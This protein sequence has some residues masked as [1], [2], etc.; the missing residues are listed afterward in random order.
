MKTTFQ[1]FLGLISSLVFSIYAQPADCTSDFSIFVEYAKT[2]NY[3]AAYTP[4]K[5][6]VKNCPSYHQATYLYGEKILKFKIESATTKADKEVFVR[7]LMKMYDDYDTHFPDNNKGNGVSKAMAL[8]DN[9]IGTPEEQYALLDKAFTSD[10]KNF[11]SA[12]A[13]YA[14]FSLYVDQY[15][16]GKG[17]ELQQVFDRYDEISEKLED[18][19]KV[20]SDEKDKLIVKQETEALTAKEENT[21]K[22][23]ETNMEAFETVSGSMDAKISL[24]SSCDRL[25]P[26]YQKSF[27]SKKGDAIWLQR[28]AQRLDF[29][30]CS[31]DPLFVKISE[32]LHKL[33]P[34]AKSAY[35]LGVA[36]K[37]N[38]N[39]AK[40]VEYFNQAADLQSDNNE[41]A[42]IYYQVATMFGNGNKSQARNYAKK[43]L[44]VKPSY[45]KA[46]LLIAQLYGSSSNEC[47]DTPFEKRAVNWLAAQM[48]QKAGQV[49][50]TIKAQANQAAATYLKI[51][52]SKSDI[53][54][55]AMQ[56][57]TINLKCWI[58]ESV[59]VPNL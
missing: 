10:K 59:K 32:A 7:D 15:T 23:L 1:L 8:V 33:N 42:K 56:G 12:K 53:F 16:N 38:K 5:N 9:E 4:W 18:E 52:P 24:L 50:S 27:D 44:N 13:M 29:K 57:K 48:A 55:A 11:T 47:G 14:Y 25:I 37:N 17:V 36:A 51:A 30:G 58:G 31:T 35:N 40:A 39:T 34:S 19:A 45:G 41:K 3:E 2:K 54:Q 22:V 28:A 20:L 26:F 21:F 6:V 43:A 46:Y 49:D